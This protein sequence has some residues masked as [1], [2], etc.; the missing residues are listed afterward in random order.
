MRRQVM[1]LTT[2]LM[3]M[4]SVVMAKSTD[5]RY[6]D[7]VD[8]AK[9]TVTKTQNNQGFQNFTVDDFCA[10]NAC[11]QDVQNPDQ[12]RY[13][14]DPQSMESDSAAEMANNEYGQM[15][16]DNFNKGRPTIDPNDP[17]YSKALRYIDDAKTIAHGGTSKYHD[18]KTGQTCDY[19]LSEK[20]CTRP[21]NLPYTCEKKPYV[22][23]ENTT[24]GYKRF[25]PV[26]LNSKGFT[27]NLPETVTVTRIDIPPGFRWFDA[28]NAK[29]YVN[30]QYVGAVGAEFIFLGSCA[31]GDC[32]TELDAERL[33]MSIKT[34]KVKFELR[35]NGG[36]GYDRLDG[37]VTVY[38][39]KKTLVMDW[40]N[41][42]SAHLPECKK[43]SETCVEGGGSR[44]INGVYQY[45]P[46]WKYKQ[47]YQ[48]DFEDTCT[49]FSDCSEISTACNKTSYGVCVQDK[50]NMRCE[51]QTCRDSSLVCGETSF[52]LDGDCFVPEATQSDDFDQA[53][54][55]L[56]AV[57]E[58]GKGLGDP[59]LIFTGK[60]QQCTKKAVG[61]SDC[62]KDG[63][64]GSDIGLAQC[65]EEEKGLGKAKENLLTISLGE[66]CAE[67]VLGA[68]I[69]KKKSYCVYE[70]KLAR[71]IQEQGK[72]QIGLDFGTAKHPD[73]SAI[74]PEQM[75]QMD[76]SQIDF[77]DFYT[78]L[79]NSTSIPDTN[80]IQQ[81]LKDSMQEKQ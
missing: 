22:K 74:T 6:Y 32:W 72:P 69:R 7:N 35:H 28:E 62:C 13:R 80:Q 49:A 23:S 52:C 4:S 16:T 34:N 46:C 36:A 25:N 12:T 18:C 58:A 42:C 3:A 63:G 53:A 45:M 11:K 56:A 71:I 2:V 54:S 57:S 5:Q 55:N 30:G 15:V 29:A 66:Y 78:D 39:Q 14:N 33:H 61:F 20:Q 81:R 17:G 19:S 77:S 51:V 9:Q 67:K 44:W 38:W 41:S 76:F 10:D 1:I 75:Q 31:A 8:W 64:W 59:P 70:S 24:N 79:N 27:L 37:G 73:C 21:T 48:C 40:K 50:V 26:R 47:T 60:P 65:S 43:V 68:C